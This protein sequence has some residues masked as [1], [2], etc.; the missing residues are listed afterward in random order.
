[1]ISNWTHRT[2]CEARNSYFPL[3]FGIS[4]IGHAV[5]VELLQRPFSHNITQCMQNN[6]A[7][8]TVSGSPILC[9]G[10]DFNVCEMTI[11]SGD[12]GTFDSLLTRFRPKITVYFLQPFFPILSWS[13]S[14][15]KFQSI[16]VSASSRF[17]DGLIPFQNSSLF[18]SALLLGSLLT[19]F[20]SKI[21]IYSLQWFFPILYC[22]DSVP[23]FQYIFFNTFPLLLNSIEQEI[24]EVNHVI[25]PIGIC[26][27]LLTVPVIGAALIRGLPP[28]QLWT[29]C[30]CSYDSHDCKIQELI[31]SNRMPS[32]R[33]V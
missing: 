25:A 3:I 1:M 10:S 21:P 28:L 20:C 23:K 27:C 26:G 16:L 14:V 6:T 30:P 22:P 32:C 13:D 33:H 11:Q 24:L 7:A 31:W 9:P 5:P 17:F 29:R 19:R 2:I 18:L 15:L 12:A 8:V 4:K